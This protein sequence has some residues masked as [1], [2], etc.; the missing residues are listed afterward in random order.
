MT[1]SVQRSKGNLISF[2]WTLRIS[3]C[4][5]TVYEKSENIQA[6]RGG[7]WVKVKREQGSRRSSPHGNVNDLQDKRGIKGGS[8]RIEAKWRRSEEKWKED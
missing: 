2:L 3:L 7:G 4:G 6:K 8:K 5:G 1:K